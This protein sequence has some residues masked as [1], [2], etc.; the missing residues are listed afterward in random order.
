MA[1]VLLLCQ[2]RH[3]TGAVGGRDRKDQKDQRD[4]RDL[5]GGEEARA[6]E[7]V[8]GRMARAVPRDWDGRA[9]Q[10]KFSVR[11]SAG[12]NAR[13]WADGRVEVTAGMLPFVAND[14]EL[15]AVLAHEMAHVYCRH[16]WRRAVESWAVLAG[17]VA[18]GMI[19]SSRRDDPGTATAI[20][21]GLFLTISSTA[22]TAR[23]RAQEL[24]ADAVSLDL[25]RRADYPA[26]AA[27]EFWT[28]YSVARSDEKLGKGGWWMPH[29]PDALR[30]RRLRGLT[31][32]PDKA[33]RPKT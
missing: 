33:A 19:W 25:L 2:C 31:A 21:S 8:T 18:V 12:V 4:G 5:R 27:L 28:R 22:L 7:R 17:S 24:E 20:G 9:I 23:Q 16:G 30:L 10:W 14:A 13:S 26:A 1:V 11:E 15:A 3:G 32:T 29:P 6:W